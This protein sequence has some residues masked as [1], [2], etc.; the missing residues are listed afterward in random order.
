MFL[1]LS[2]RKMQVD[3]FEILKGVVYQPK[4]NVNHIIK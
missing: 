2:A 4:K 3:I 1:Y